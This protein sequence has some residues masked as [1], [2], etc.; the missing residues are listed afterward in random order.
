[1]ANKRDQL[2]EKTKEWQKEA[3]NASTRKNTTPAE[4]M[5]HQ[6]TL[7]KCAEDVEKI[8]NDNQ[9]S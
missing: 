8:V 9:K 4:D 5:Q 7:R 6:R 2:L 3:D 1:M